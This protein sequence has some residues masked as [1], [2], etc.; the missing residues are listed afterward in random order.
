M[1]LNIPNTELPGNSFLKGLDTGSSMFSRMINPVIQRENMM[2]QWKQHLDSLAF[3]KQQMAHAER[4]DDLKRRVLQ[5]RLTG[6]HNANDPK[7][8][9]K[10]LQEKL[11]YIQNLGAQNTQDVTSGMGNTSIE[12]Q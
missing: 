2:R 5:E 4:N 1:A 3:Q 12:A 10:Q 11:N 6:L 8:A 7:F 9:M